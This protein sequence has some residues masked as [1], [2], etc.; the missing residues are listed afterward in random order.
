MKARTPL[1]V[2]IGLPVYN[3]ENYLASTLNSL[4]AQ[5]YGDF[6]VVVCDNASTDG[7]QDICR[8]FAARDR[9]V[10]YFRN[11]HNIGA[12]PNHN[13][14]FELSR[15]EYF[16]WSAHDDL[17]APTFLE[18][19][20]AALD[21]DPTAVLS[22]P[23]I[24]YIDAAGEVVGE[25]PY[26][27]ALAT[28]SLLPEE[29]FCSLLLGGCMNFQIFGL[30][31]AAALR[32]TPLQGG[33]DAADQVLLARMALLGRFHEIPEGLLFY[34]LHAG[35]SINLGH[36]PVAYS[37]WFDPANEGRILFPHWRYFAEYWKALREADLSLR[38]RARCYVELTRWFRWS[39]KRL[40]QDLKG[41]ARIARR[42]LGAGRQSARA[43]ADSTP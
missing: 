21:R 40:R 35:Q 7:T 43:E 26:N 2:S 8:E 29:R 28:G 20:V 22:C 36:D 19:C 4:L 34:R 14:C 16:K 23:E 15:G 27:R 24:L 5:T 25:S 6:E 10:R 12:A 33:Y 41:A 31:R 38:A 11:P 13:R 17:C 1:R 18:K 39:S 3:G 42:H 9:R 30:M 32:R 37:V